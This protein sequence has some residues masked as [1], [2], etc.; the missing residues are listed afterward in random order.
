MQSGTAR[1]ARR[2]YHEIMKLL[3]IT[4][5]VVLALA[6]I[7][8]VVAVSLVGSSGNW[9]L[10][11]GWGVLSLLILLQMRRPRLRPAYARTGRK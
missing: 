11:V 3:E 8:T 10:A 4:I 5:A 2:H 6:I 7:C 1:A 9:P